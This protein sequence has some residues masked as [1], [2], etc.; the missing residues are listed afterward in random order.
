MNNCLIYPPTNI[1]IEKEY[2]M[3]MVSYMCESLASFDSVKNDKEFRKEV[4]DLF[5]AHH[6][7]AAEHPTLRMSWEDACEFAGT[8][9][10]LNTTDIMHGCLE[11][12]GMLY[13]SGYDL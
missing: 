13:E 9:K 12:Q 2:Y 5:L 6:N 10:Y 8:G 1:T 4:V 3:S 7:V 11:L